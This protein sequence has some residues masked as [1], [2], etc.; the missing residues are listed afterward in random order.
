MTNRDSNEGIRELLSELSPA[1]AESVGPVLRS[2]Q[3]MAHGVVPEPSRELAALIEAN[4]SQERAS[5]R[6]IR[7]R[8]VVFSLA[9]IGALAAG[10]GTAAAVSPEFRTA[11]ANAIAGIV[12]ATPFGNHAGVPSTPSSP[13]LPTRSPGTAAKTGATSHPTPTPSDSGHSK[14]GG[15][16]PGH[17][18]PKSTS[19]PTP[20]SSPPGKGHGGGAP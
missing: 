1:D 20:H 10:A 4:G 6:R 14:G 5:H 12:N 8:G 16:S 7:H 11:A 18:N 3:S 2:L 13:A 15:K 9:L 19:H 17:A